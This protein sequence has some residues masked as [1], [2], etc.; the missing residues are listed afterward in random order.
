MENKKFIDGKGEDYDLDESNCN[1]EINGYL[2][3]LIINGSNNKIAIKGNIIYCE[4]IGN[5]CQLEIFSPCSLSSIIFRGDNN[6]L[7]HSSFID[8]LNIDNGLNNKIIKKDKN[9]QNNQNILKEDDKF[10]NPKF[11]INF[12]NNNNINSLNNDN[13][14]NN[15][16]E[17]KNEQL[18]YSSDYLNYYFVDYL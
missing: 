3:N 5:S 14:S 17:N 8:P 1:L 13:G 15:E 18:N 4:I 9:D 11:K 12:S 6:I 2:S 10:E 16:N 7:K